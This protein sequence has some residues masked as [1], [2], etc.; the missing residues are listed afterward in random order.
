MGHGGLWSESGSWG[1]REGK[2]SLHKKSGN[3]CLC[4]TDRNA[5]K[6]GIWLAD[7]E[8]DW[9]VEAFSDV[10]II[11]TNTQLLPA[12]ADWPKFEC[13]V[14]GWTW[15]E[16]RFPDFPCRLILPMLTD[17]KEMSRRTGYLLVK[18]SHFL[19]INTFPQCRLILFYSG[20]RQ[21]ILL[22]DVNVL[23][24]KVL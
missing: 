8:D 18:I 9:Q 16:M 5:V 22:V 14:L 12:S 23:V 15:T 2:M 4:I 3:L 20:Q 17:P 6:G 10:A 21:T 1:E 24:V 11:E 7:T 13:D 19:L